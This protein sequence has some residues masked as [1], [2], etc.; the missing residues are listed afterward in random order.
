MRIND[1]VAIKDVSIKI[2]GKEEVII[3]KNDVLQCEY[4]DGE[5]LI[6]ASDYQL[7]L[8]EKNLDK[9]MNITQNKDITN[10]VKKKRRKSKRL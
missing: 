2:R 9:Y 1:V 7:H 10:R 6:K 3:K 5:Y 8:T 4:V